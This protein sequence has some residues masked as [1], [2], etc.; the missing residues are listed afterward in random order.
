MLCSVGFV[1]GVPSFLNPCIKCLSRGH[2][3]VIIPDPFFSDVDLEIIQKQFFCSLSV[4]IEEAF[5]IF[6]HSLSNKF[7]NGT[8]INR[9]LPDIEFISD[10]VLDVSLPGGERHHQTRAFQHFSAL[11]WIIIFLGI[12]SRQK[13]VGVLDGPIKSFGSSGHEY[14]LYR[15]R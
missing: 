15:S 14:D 13:A 10:P 12:K 6:I 5:E 11:S 9:F 7:S 2:A 4:R 8:S 3:I 1:S